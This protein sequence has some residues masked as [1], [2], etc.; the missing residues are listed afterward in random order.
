M[1]ETTAYVEAPTKE[2]LADLERDVGVAS[3]F[4]HEVLSVGDDW[5]FVIK[6]H[7]LIEAAVS[8]LLAEVAGQPALLDVFTQLELSNG[9]TGKIAFAKALECLEDYERGSIRKLSELRNQLVHGWSD[10]DAQLRGSGLLGGY[11]TAVL[12]AVPEPG[13]IR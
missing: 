10:L 8:H 3:G 5:S 6:V 4:F 11:P 7:A 2:D 12:G 9:R 1:T 13:R